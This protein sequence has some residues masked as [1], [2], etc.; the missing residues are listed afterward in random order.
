MILAQYLAFLK[1]TWQKN[2]LK[3]KKR[4]LLGIILGIMKVEQRLY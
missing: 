4:E 1:L 3:K 2:I